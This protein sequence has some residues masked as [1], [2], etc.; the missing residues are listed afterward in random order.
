MAP[1]SGIYIKIADNVKF[2]LNRAVTIVS[3]WPEAIRSYIFFLMAE[4]ERLS[5]R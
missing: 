1:M 4:H 5:N 2:I 3:A